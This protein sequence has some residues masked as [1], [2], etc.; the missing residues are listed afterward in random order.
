MRKRNVTILK[1]KTNNY[2]TYGDLALKLV[3]DSFEDKKYETP[4]IKKLTF[5]KPKT[6]IVM[7]CWQQSYSANGGDGC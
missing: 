5:E 3:G 4:K 2:V 7:G 6:T 1:D